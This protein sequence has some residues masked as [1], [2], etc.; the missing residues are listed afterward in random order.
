MRD[1][2]GVFADHGGYALKQDLLQ[3]CSCEN[4]IDYGTYSADTVDYPD[5]ANK[6]AALLKDGVIQRA[7]LICGT[8]IGI[9]MAANRYPW[10]R[11]FVA[12]NITEV[13]LAREH[14]DANIICFS[15]RYQ[16][17]SDVLSFLDLFM[18]TPFEG[19]R[20]QKRVDIFSKT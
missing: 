9:C 19:G 16:S 6:A 2:I 1:K 12:H 3:F 7:I 4:C 11:A 5:F 18:N 20:H 15:G 13:K 8:G 14:N 10:V 17:L